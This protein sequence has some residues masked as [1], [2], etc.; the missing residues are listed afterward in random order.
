[1]AS[2]PEGDPLSFQILAGNH[3][4]AFR[5][6]GN[7]IVVNN[8]AAMDYETYPS[9]SLIINVTDGISNVQGTFTINLNNLP[10]ETGNDILTASAPGMVGNPAINASNRTVSLIVSQVDISALPVNFT[11]SKGATS[12]PVSGTIMNLL[13]PQSISVTSEVGSSQTWTI[14]ASYPVSVSDNDLQNIMIWP[15]PATDIL[16]ISGVPSGSILNII[17][18][19][20]RLVRREIMN[21]S[22]Q[23]IDIGSLKPVVYYLI[24]ESGGRVITQK[25]VRN[26]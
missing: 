20:G 4:D 23:A 19:S 10:D 2:D 12:N 17:D 6:E 1:V 21:A 11:I 25:F 18:S 8:S 15:N 7:N 13:T 24:I 5:L 16:Y 14:S 26:Q 3:M 9:F 22:T